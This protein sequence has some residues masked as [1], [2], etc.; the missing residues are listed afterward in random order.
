VSGGT[1]TVSAA[2]ALGTGHLSVSNGAVCVVQNP[3]ALGSG[4]YVYADGTL[5]LAH[6]GTNTVSRLYIGGV[7]QPAGVWNAANNPAHFAGVGSLNVTTGRAS[8]PVPLFVAPAAGGIQLTWANAAFDLY[9]TPS[10]VAPVVWTPVTNPPAYANGQWSVVLPPGTN[11]SR[12][13]RL[14]Q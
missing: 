4:A 14:Q 6:S 5:N 2:G 10:L 1:L 13:Y 8:G 11:C 12:F 9:S 7:L 3:G